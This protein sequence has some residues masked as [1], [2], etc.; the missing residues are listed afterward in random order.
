MLKIVRHVMST[1]FWSL[2]KQVLSLSVLKLSLYVREVL[3]L[4]TVGAVLIM[5]SFLSEVFTY[6]HMKRE[7][8]LIK[9][10]CVCVS[11]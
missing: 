1:S 4:K 11:C 8:Y 9:I 6:H 5:E 7:I 2:M 3:I 10:L